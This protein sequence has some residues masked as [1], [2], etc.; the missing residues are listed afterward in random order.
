MNTME[1]LFHALLQDVYSAE[2]ELTKTLP[3]LANEAKDPQW[4]KA[5]SAHHKETEEHV[6]RLERSFEMMG[7][8]ATGRKCEAILGIIAEGE[9]V[10]KKAD[11]HETEDAGLT[12]SGQAV[13]HYEIARYDTLC[14]WANMI[15]KPR[16]ANMLHDTLKEEKQAE[17]LLTQIADRPVNRRVT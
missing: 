7:K 2:Q 1:D 5:F 10:I 16:I 13:E 12:A 6:R 17:A 14:S 9:Q 11:N 8:P 15:G 3:K 4:T